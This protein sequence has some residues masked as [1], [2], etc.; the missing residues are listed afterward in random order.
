MQTVRK[1]RRFAGWVHA[2]KGSEQYFPRILF[3]IA[4]E[5]KSED[6]VLPACIYTVAMERELNTEWDK[7]NFPEFMSLLSRK[8]DGEAGGIGLHIVEAASQGT[9]QMSTWSKY[10]YDLMRVKGNQADIQAFL[11]ASKELVISLE[12]LKDKIF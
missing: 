11:E 8:P 12:R 7:R 5:L 1:L 3:E 10:L 2:E 4:A 6:V 9:F